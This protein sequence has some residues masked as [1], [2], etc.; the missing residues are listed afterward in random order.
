MEKSQGWEEVRAEESRRWERG[1]G[2][3]QEVGD[4]QAQNVLPPRPGGS[5]RM[6]DVIWPLAHA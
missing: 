3:L 2:S 4:C 1:L 5:P 6:W